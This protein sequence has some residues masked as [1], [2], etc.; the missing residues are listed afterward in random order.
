MITDMYGEERVQE[1]RGK[2]NL[3]IC[4]VVVIHQSCLHIVPGGRDNAVR[5]FFESA[6]SQCG[7]HRGSLLR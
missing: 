4:L 3:T 1:Y 5:E 6:R 2:S 7:H